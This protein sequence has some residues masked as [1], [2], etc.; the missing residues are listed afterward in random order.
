MQIEGRGGLSLDTAWRDGA[1]AYLGINVAGFP[2]LFL[3]YGPNTNLGHNSI[4]FMLECQGRY[5]LEG[6]RAMAQNG[7]A[8]LEVRAEVQAAHDAEIQ[9]A[10]AGTVW[11]AIDKSWYKNDRGRITNNWPHSTARYWMRTR[12]LDLRR[13]IAATRARVEAIR[14]E[15][16]TGRP[17]AGTTATGADLASSSSI[18]AR[19]AAL[20]LTCSQIDGRKRR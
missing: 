17:C 1:A 15:P 10:L 20:S 18:Q 6:L 13:Y 12:R 5:I 11:A 8:S 14:S 4:L 19:S 3:M 2:N 16:V 7:L 9:R